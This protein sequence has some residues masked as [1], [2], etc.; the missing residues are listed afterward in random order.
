MKKNIQEIWFKKHQ[1]AGS[2]GKRQTN[3]RKIHE[4]ELWRSS[5]P[6]E[7]VWEERDRNVNQKLTRVMARKGNSSEI[8][9]H[10]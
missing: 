7:L 1:N 6:R 9:Q 5:I 3:K 10:S 2:L 4:M 8:L